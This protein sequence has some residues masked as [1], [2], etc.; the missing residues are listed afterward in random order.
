MTDDGN[1]MDVA[2][3]LYKLRIVVDDLDSYWLKPSDLREIEQSIIRLHQLLKRHRS[4]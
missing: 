1:M 2:D 3:A 4:K